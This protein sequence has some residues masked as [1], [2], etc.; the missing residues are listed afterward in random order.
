MEVNKAL[1]G[2][3]SV[4]T[5]RG[6]NSERTFGHNDSM[7]SRIPPDQGP[8]PA[9]RSYVPQGTIELPNPILATIQQ[10]MCVS[11]TIVVNRFDD[12]CC[13]G[14]IAEGEIP[15]VSNGSLKMDEPF[16][17]GRNS[18]KSDGKQGIY[19]KLKPF[20]PLVVNKS[21]NVCELETNHLCNFLCLFVLKLWKLFCTFPLVS[22]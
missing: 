3:N 7:R 19:L 4:F 13:N 16:T 17:N 5:R 10:E 1:A 22:I 11:S 12:E 21:G 14:S 18:T 2:E 9:G 8:A 20:G 15:N 6:R